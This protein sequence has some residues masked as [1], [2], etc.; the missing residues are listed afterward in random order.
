VFY[1]ATDGSQLYVVTLKEGRNILRQVPLTA[2]D[3]LDTPLPL[4]G[5]AFL[6]CAIPGGSAVIMAGSL[7]EFSPGGGGD[8]WPLWR[9]PVGGGAPQRIGDLLGTSADVSPDGRSLALVRGNAIILASIDGSNPREVHPL[10]SAVYGLKWAPDGR[11]LRFTALRPGDSQG[12]WIW[13]ASVTGGAPS[14]LWPGS[15]GDWTRDGRHYVFQRQRDLFVA[16]ESRWARWR[17]AA[18]QPLTFGALRHMPVGSSSDGSRLIAFLVPPES[19]QGGTL[20]RYDPG[21]R[22]FEPALGGES[23]MYAEPS[24]HGTWLAWVRYPEGRLWRS[25]PDGSERLRLTSPP[26]RAHL[27]RWSPDGTR[28]VYSHQV[29]PFRVR[30][31][32]PGHSHRVHERR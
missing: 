18:P 1:A 14:P 15:Y 13:E 27:P 17:A 16:T 8:G 28:I 29:D 20:M 7:D 26:S 2:G 23:A 4:R 21:K 12:F 25:R 32:S 30:A 3:A 19:G 5:V 22:A 10:A 31:L 24:P 6:F 11:R 9:V